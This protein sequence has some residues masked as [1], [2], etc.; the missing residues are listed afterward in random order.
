MK[1]YCTQ[2]DGECETCSLVNYNRDCY[3]NPFGAAWHGKDVRDI[4]PMSELNKLRP[5]PD[6]EDDLGI[7]GIH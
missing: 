7:G 2:N 3:N 4:P 1:F 5:S 6:I